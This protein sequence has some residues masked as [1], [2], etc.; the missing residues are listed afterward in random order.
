MQRSEIHQR[1]NADL[2]TAMRLSIAVSENQYLVASIEVHRCRLCVCVCVCVLTPV[3]DTAV[4]AHNRNSIH[5]RR[6]SVPPNTTTTTSNASYFSRMFLWLCLVSGVLGV[7][8]VPP[9]S[10][11]ACICVYMV[12]INYCIRFAHTGHCVLCVEKR[13]TR[14]TQQSNEHVFVG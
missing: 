14:Q 5:D 7:I 2:V 4:A 13:P 1:S 9:I 11:S 6:E 8:G 12:Y 10:C 3:K